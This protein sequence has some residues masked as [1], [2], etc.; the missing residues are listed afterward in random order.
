MQNKKF[1]WIAEWMSRRTHVICLFVK[2]RMD[3]VNTIG[4]KFFVKILEPWFSGNSWQ[5]KRSQAAL[6]WV[7]ARWHPADCEVWKS[8][9]LQSFLNKRETQIWPGT[10]IPLQEFIKDFADGDG[11]P[12]AMGVLFA[13]GEIKKFAFFKLENFQNML[14][15]QWKFDSFLKNFK[16]I[17]RVFDDFLKF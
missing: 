2:V 17:L 12:G 1:K 15:N 8:K 6:Q 5:L 16:G 3:S 13:I 10:K 7:W 4:K 9:Y 11:V 14:K